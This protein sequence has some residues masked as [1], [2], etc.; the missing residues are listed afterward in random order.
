MKRKSS[1]RVNDLGLTGFEVY[2]IMKNE[3]GIQL[4]LAETYVSLGCRRDWG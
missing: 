1:F 3:F 2:D 4:E